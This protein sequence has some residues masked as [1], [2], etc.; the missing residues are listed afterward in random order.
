MNE[1]FL[2]EFEQMV[3]LSI[4]RL[5][6]NAYGTTI[7]QVLAETI[8]RDVSIG[9]LYTTLERLERK[10]FLVGELGE[11]SR[12]RGGRAK[13]YFS[14]TGEGEQSLK[15]SRDAMNKLW[16]GVHIRSGVLNY[17]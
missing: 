12:E 17:G 10:G 15:R 11:A 5:G 6:S 3:L 7:R 14:L 1:K 2:G 9:A 16:Q 8:R 13:K 4:I